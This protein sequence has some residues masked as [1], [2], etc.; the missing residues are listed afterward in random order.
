MLAT[1]QKHRE[2]LPM[3]GS[4]FRSFTSEIRV[5]LVAP[6]MNVPVIPMWSHFPVDL[7]GVFLK[8]ISLFCIITFHVFI[9]SLRLRAPWGRG[10]DL[11]CEFMNLSP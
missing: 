7:F 4:C 1:C 9:F 5:G 8:P 11:I 3:P 6:L 10:S 2:G